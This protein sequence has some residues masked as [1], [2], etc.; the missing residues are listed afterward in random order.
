MINF[1]L[2]SNAKLNHML[3]DV[4]ET[5]K[6]YTQEQLQQINRLTEIGESLASIE[7]PEKL[8]KK[9][10]HEAVYFTEA[11]GAVLFTTD[12]ENKELRPQQ[13]YFEK[14]DKIGK[15]QFLYSVPL[16]YKNGQK[17]Y[18]SIISKSWH[19]KKAYNVCELNKQKINKGHLFKQLNET[20]EIEPS[21]FMV[22]PLTTSDRD[23]HGILLLIK[24]KKNQLSATNFSN[25]QTTIIK[26]LLSQ[27]AICLYNFKM[28]K[29]FDDLIFKYVKSIMIAHQNKKHKYRQNHE[30]NVVELVEAI[31][32]EINNSENYPFID[33]KLS[34]DELD[35][36]SI[37]AWLHDIGILATPDYIINK[38]TKLSDLNDKI[39][40][41]R[42]RFEL[43]EQEII[44]ES[45][46]I[47]I[48][49]KQK[50]VNSR[51]LK[52]LPLWLKIIEDANQPQE[53]LSDSIIEDL[54]KINSKSLLVN[55]RNF[56]LLT[57]DELKKLIVKR[58]TLSFNELK[59]I[60]KHVEMTQLMVAELSFPHLYKNA[61]LYAGQHHEK[62]NGQGYPLGLDET[63]LS[64]QSR[65]IAVADIFEAISSNK[66]TY[67]KTNT[68]S[69]IID[70]LVGFVERNSID[71]NIV[72][73]LFCKNIFD[74]YSHLLSDSQKDIR[75]EAE[76]LQY[77]QKRFT[78]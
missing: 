26:S 67:K 29:L 75:S 37:A 55:N 23:V 22:S 38:E 44:S 46:N 47:T 16:F 59:V 76:M 6:Q 10:I 65:I 25:E 78:N 11:D 27:A 15:E 20:F 63:E 2:N 73:I 61:G 32:L 74:K 50:T 34:K 66:R 71:K 41:I 58:G 39:E 60:Q 72:E 3:N 62:L 9:I 18:S 30:Q 12:K 53:D 42:L 69:E 28:R 14:I 17:N 48:D 49:D 1:N 77:F 21:C 5:I 56:S 24:I 52:K 4:T 8:M 7:S 70:I 57:D 13:I 45:R 40:I 33:Y 19:Y 36:L 64:L 68:I 31:C 35:E 43:I 51:M 54:K